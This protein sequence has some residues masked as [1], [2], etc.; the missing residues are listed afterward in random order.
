MERGEGQ[1]A[2]LAEMKREVVWTWVAQAD[3]QRAFAHFEERSPDAG[4]RLLETTDSLLELTIRHPYIARAWC[5]LVRRHVLQRTHYGLFYVVEAR[6]IVV[7]AF[8]DLREDPDRLRREIMD[9]LP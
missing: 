4:V 3:M 1:A 5:G 2:R 8:R 6:R 9:R 7:I